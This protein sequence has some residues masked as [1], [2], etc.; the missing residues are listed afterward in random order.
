MAFTISSSLQN[1]VGRKYF[2]CSLCIQVGRNGF[3]KAIVVLQCLT[4]ECGDVGGGTPVSAK[5]SVINGAVIKTT[6]VDL[7]T[8]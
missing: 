5:Q 7:D 8:M 3:N 2:S 4:V 6:L 1:A